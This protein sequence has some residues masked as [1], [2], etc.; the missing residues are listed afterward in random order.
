VRDITERKAVEK[1][2]DDLVATVSH[3]LRTPLA[4]IRGFVELMLLRE[5]GP[6]DRKE[7][8]EILDKETR[9]LGKLIDDFL[10][11][12]RLESRKQEYRF[13]QIDLRGP[14][15]HAA[16]VIA[17][18]S[19]RHEVEI[20]FPEEPVWVRADADRFEQCVLNLLSNAVKYSP[21]GGL[22]VLGAEI[23]GPHV[24][25]RVRDQGVGMTSETIEKLFTKFF[26]ADSTVTL[27]IGGTGLGLALVK[28]IAEAHQGQIEVES[29]PGKGSEFRLT[30]PRVEAP[31]P[32][33]P[34]EA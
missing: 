28:E 14:L 5:Y 16:T 31:E 26:R 7:F 27:G 33:K 34:D 12:Q 15:E 10:D 18:A 2:K 22:V 25:V 4:S 11:L 1:L 24:V 3:E 32:E 23:A 30:L 21:D 6:E 13:E 8:L 9:R 17:A 29:E 19:D 20:D